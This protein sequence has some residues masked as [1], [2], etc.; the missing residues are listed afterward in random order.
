MKKFSGIFLLLISVLTISCSQIIDNYYENEAQEN[1]TNP[2][3]GKYVGSYSG[4]ESGSLTIIVEK[5]GYCRIIRTLGGNTLETNSFVNDNG[6]FNGYV[7]TN[8]FALLG[9]LQSKKGNWKN[10]TLTGNWNVV[11]Q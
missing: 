7:N 4:D 1:Y 10:Q 5:K 9:N 6:A 3:Q 11:K 8:D 2:Y